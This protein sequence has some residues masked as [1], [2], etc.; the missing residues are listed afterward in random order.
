MQIVGLQPQ[1]K[2][3]DYLNQ[4][5]VFVFPTQLA[6]SLGLV[7]VEAMACGCPV[8]ASDF[9]APGDYV[10]DGI[11]G[12]KFPVGDSDTLAMLLEKMRTLSENERTALKEG[13]LATAQQ[14]A[15]N[16]VT[17]ALKKILLE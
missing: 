10:K 11:N 3:P 13:A 7:A 17:E 8:L 15:T 4:M 5:D 12:Y 9:A 6:E 2:L 1:T 16:K 14:F